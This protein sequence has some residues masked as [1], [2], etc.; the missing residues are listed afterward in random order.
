MDNQQFDRFPL[1]E[2]IQIIRAKGFDVSI[3]QIIQ[4]QSLLLSTPITRLNVKELKY[5]LAPILA[6]NDEEQA[7]IYQLVDDYIASKSTVSKPLPGFW[8]VFAKNK[9]RLFYLKLIG[10]LSLVAIALAFYIIQT[11]HPRTATSSAQPVQ[12]YPEIQDSAP[13]KTEPDTNKQPGQTRKQREL[14]GKPDP[15][16][17][18]QYADPILLKRRDINLQMSGLF[19]ILLGIIL[20]FFLFEEK[21][22]AI[23]S[24]RKKKAL[25]MGEGGRPV[26]S[27]EGDHAQTGVMLEDSE[28]VTIEFPEKNYVIQ[29]SPELASI[30]TGLKQPGVAERHELN[31]RKSI[32]ASTRNA[33][34]AAPV[35]DEIVKERKYIALV[36]G[37]PDAHLARLFNYFID[38]LQ[39]AKLPVV[40][41]TYVTDIK[42]LKDDAGKSKT[43]YEVS[44]RFADH[45]LLLFDD[46]RNLFAGDELTMRK[47]ISSS[48]HRWPARY[49]ITSTPLEDWSHLEEALQANGF[50]TVPAEIEAIDLLVTAITR[51]ATVQR[52]EL[53][54]KI[55]DP[56]SVAKVDFDS[57]TGLKKYLADP[58]LFQLVCSLAVYPKLSWNLTLA[59]FSSFLTRMPS[60][61]QSAALSYNTLLKISRIPWLQHNEL[62]QSL[63]LQLLM[64]LE[65]RNEIIAR[66]TLLQLLK[67]LKQD[68]PTESLA[69]SEI[70]V[71]FDLNAFFLFA[72][73]EWTYE[74][75]SYTKQTVPD[76]W[77]HLNEWP[78]KERVR[79]GQSGL[80]PLNEDG[81]HQSVDEYFLKEDAIEIQN[82]KFG[83]VAAL[84]LPAMILYILF[85]IFQPDLV[86]D[87][88]GFKNVSF[89]ARLKWD[90]SCNKKF[91]SVSV[92]DGAAVK[93]QSS[94]EETIF[95]RDVNPEQPVKLE[96]RDGKGG[97]R[98]IEIGAKNSL[99]AI[100][101]ACQ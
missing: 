77:V 69:Y 22:K 20:S 55:R 78:L 66:E 91:T 46:C 33:G 13:G 42:V 88:Y 101:L 8:K 9:K 50:V 5:L 47:N 16:A 60:A 100:S 24:K 87:G 11:L 28:P 83:R 1:G 7:D 44:D 99:A 23:D 80:M 63:R 48:L 40:R 89:M 2:L 72:H 64:E 36:E 14:A 61:G 38:F 81:R 54:S 68:L 79:Q 21:Q 67:E 98:V 4:I 12:N 74:S 3:T 94:G 70:E 71:Q 10:A 17:S 6:K 62:D 34:F 75:Y 86:Y 53:E 85:S 45:H 92:S 39:A 56:Y 37:Q 93:I 76:Y 27:S 96:F 59:L 32:Y 19:G 43:L 52:S 97:S 35:F 15:F 73:D 18:V 25:D 65:S 51:G 82:I 29:R 41:F 57:A 90:T 95:I 31:I 49:V 58:F 84:F 30:K 26:N